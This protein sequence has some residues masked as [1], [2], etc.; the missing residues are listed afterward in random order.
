MELSYLENNK[1]Q[2]EITKSISIGAFSPMAL[3]DLK[4]NGICDFNIPEV[5]FDLDFPGQYLRRIKSVSITIPC[6]VGPYTGVNAKLTLLSN[7]IRKDYSTPYGYDGT[8]SDPNFFHNFVGIQSIATSTVQNDSGVFQLN[9]EDSRYLPFEGAGVI[10]SWRLE[11]PTEFHQ[12]D[13]NS[14]S[15]VILTINYTAKDGGDSLRPT[16]NLHVQSNINKALDQLETAEVGFQRLVS[17]KNEFPD[18]FYQFL[19]PAGGGD[20]TTKLEINKKYFPFL[21][22][23]REI[24]L[25]DISIIIQPKQGVTIDPNSDITSLNWKINKSSSI[26][27]FDCKKSHKLVLR[28]FW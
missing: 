11:L 13:Y 9:F 24:M 10:S 2:Y 6:V 12:F 15:D 26:N 27:V 17:L 5:L 3:L 7:R 1:R 8:S 25:D 16:V 19:N 28:H 18:N 20:L 21:F 4:E 22:K 23:D 14:I